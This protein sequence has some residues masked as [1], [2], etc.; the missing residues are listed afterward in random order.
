MSLVRAPNSNSYCARNKQYTS[1]GNIL[2]VPQKNVLITYGRM[3]SSYA[4]L[5]N[6]EKKGLKV[7]VA[8]SCRIGMGQVSFKKSGFDVYPSHYQ[9]EDKF[10]EAIKT[11]CRYRRID[12]IF[13]SHNETSVLSKHQH[14]LP[15]GVSVLLPDHQT[16]EKFNNKSISYDI[17]EELGVPTPQRIEYA[18]VDDL[19]MKLLKFSWTK[20]VVKLLTGNSSK[21]VFHCNSV[22]QTIETVKFL[23]SKFKLQP[24]RF[25]QVEE[26]VSGDG[27]GSSV[28]FWHG[29][30][31]AGFTHRRLR[32]KINTGGTSTLRE[33]SC[34]I[35]LE[36][37]AEKIFSHMNWHGLAMAEFKVCP[38]T[39]K[40]WFIEVNPRMWGSIPLAI[41]SGIEFP[42]L[43]LLC[44]EKGPEEARA[45][46]NRQSVR[47]GWRNRWLLGDMMLASKNLFI[48][49][50]KT[51]FDIVFN[52]SVNATDDFFLDDPFVFP[53]E[54]IHY[55]TQAILKRSTN[56]FEE[57]MLR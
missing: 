32:E 56:S 19:T 39:K 10:I 22:N 35:D 6:L 53:G 23:I 7:F 25:P 9:D 47:F 1:K 8:D 38:K 55:L 54:V 30:K 3:R 17:A 37:A 36:I 41:D 21:G 45:Y 57:G 46:L 52:S 13:P 43:A 15:Q 18:T 34:N 24:S 28:L 40:Y 16:I 44:A 33:A 42:Y 27:W 26:V 14:R 20:T 5:R 2:K 50:P 51:A 11:I 49:K 12:Y 4:A 29:V 48:G 31:V